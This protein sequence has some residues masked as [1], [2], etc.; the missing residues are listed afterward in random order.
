M[1]RLKQLFSSFGPAIIVAAIVLG[2]GSI[3]TSS[4]VGAQYGYPAVTAIILAVILMIAM[5]ALS[6]RIGVIYD[7]SPCDQLA[8]RLGRP[9]SVIVGAI[10]FALVAIFQYSNNVA[11]ISGLAPLF[12]SE[13]FSLTAGATP[14][15]ILVSF[16]AVVIFC[17]YRM[18]HLYD[19]IE[20]L[21]KWLIGL[22]VVAFLINFLVVF[23]SPRGYMPV[24]SK[25]EPD[26]I[27]LLGLMG[28]TFS[29]GGA[30]YQAYLVKEK[31]WKLP[32]AQRGLFDSVIS[33]SVVGVVSIVILMTAARVFHGR[34]DPVVLSG[35]GDVA[36][37][38][39][40]LFGTWA[41]VIFC[42][43][44]FAGAFSSFLVNALVGG[45]V[46]SDSLGKGSRLGEGWT[47]SLTTVAL[48]C[49][50]IVAL[51]NLSDAASTVNLITFAQALTV[52]GL[53][54]LA[55]ALLYLGTRPDLTGER[56]VPRW[57]ISLGWV[58]F[59][60]ALALAVRTSVAVLEKLGW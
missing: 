28:T 17:F 33:I 2:P 47:L 32:D 4:K 10:L 24:S 40:P 13:D 36:M 20:S 55:L 6:A 41:K 42:L 49:G 30:F 52:L 8:R 26:V 9:V 54:A 25:Q 38:L 51:F 50:L 22:M 53:P 43:G 14:A 18:R 21:M 3:L 58:G 60:V 44:I 27:V 31:G 11:I 29:V 35:V 19:S 39:Q 16:N 57:I 5:V 46:L 23:S 12:D 1:K 34:P 59:I 15:I 37:Q 56:K 45:T 7:D 48:L